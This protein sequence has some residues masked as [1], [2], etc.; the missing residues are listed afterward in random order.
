MAFQQF[1]TGAELAVSANRIQW[2]G[3]TGV[4]PLAELTLLVAPP[5]RGKTTV[6]LHIMDQASRGSDNL[7]GVAW[8]PDEHQRGILFVDTEDRTNLFADV[9]GGP[10]ENNTRSQEMWQGKG[11]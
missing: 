8:R 4:I 5:G 9:A 10:S 2:I 6:I 3:G 7:F 1:P 11:L